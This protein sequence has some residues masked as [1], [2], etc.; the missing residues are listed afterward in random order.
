MTSALSRHQ[1]PDVLSVIG[2]EVK[3]R[4]AGRNYVGLCPFHNEKT[5]SFSVS[6]EK[7]TF[8]CFGCGERG[9]VIDF[10]MKTR[11]VAFRDALAILGISG[12][13]SPKVDP[14]RERRRNLR[15]AYE[16][17]K[18]NFYDRLCR[19]SIRLHRIDRAVKEKPAIPEDT[20]WRVA[21]ETSR[22]P[23]IEMQI[24]LFLSRDEEAIFDLF[25]SGGAYGKCSN[26][27]I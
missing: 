7:Q 27:R 21:E 19:E 3:L 6:S 15:R 5:P 4:K 11:N 2:S 1:K 22:L 26:D 10:I 12:S 24:D 13:D 14:Q 17:W 20:A 25:K 16:Q 8:C 9:D 18:R 23:I